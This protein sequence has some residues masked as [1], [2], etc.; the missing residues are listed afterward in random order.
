MRIELNSGGLSSGVAIADFRSDFDSLLGKARK[1][2]SSFQT[3]RS[4]TYNMNGGVGILQDAVSQIES[5][6]A[7]EEEKVTALE[8]VQKK[9]DAFIEYVKQTDL[10][11][12]G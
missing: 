12:G 8:Q 10:K 4:F 9:A 2:V 1:T 3:I 5:R 11:V 6:L 7:V